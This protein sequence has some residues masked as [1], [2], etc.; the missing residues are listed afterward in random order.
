MKTKAMSRTGTAVQIASLAASIATFVL[1]SAPVQTT[2]PTAHADAHLERETKTADA[3]PVLA[4]A[5][6]PAPVP[7]RIDLPIPACEWTPK[8]RRMLTRMIL[9]ESSSGR[10][11]PAI[12]WTMARRW[13][14]LASVRGES[15]GDYVESTSAIL[16]AHARRT[17]RGVDDKRAAELAGLTE[18][19]ATVVSTSTSKHAEVEAMLDAWMRGEVPD[20][21]NGRS[22]MWSSR[23]FQRDERRVDC[24]GTAN[25]FFE[26]P[27][28]SHDIVVARLENV[29][30]T[31]SDN[32]ASIPPHTPQ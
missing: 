32:V 5:L 30:P 15:F 26:L 12:A 3:P 7:Q 4:S 9:I 14:G 6:H 1:I 22:F 23:W 28:I 24:G 13:R 19:Q 16:R 18:H 31:C 29:S 21:C 10:D 2:Q 25:A 27:E 11:G 8:A 17:R 20:P